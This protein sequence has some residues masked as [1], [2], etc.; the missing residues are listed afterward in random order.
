M[1]SYNNTTGASYKTYKFNSND[2][3]TVVDSSK[4][5]VMVKDDPNRMEGI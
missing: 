3:S 5:E 4:V 2:A 1:T